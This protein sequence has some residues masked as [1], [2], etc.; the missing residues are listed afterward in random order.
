MNRL[1]LYVTA[2]LLLTSTAF[3][4]KTSDPST[5]SD[6]STASNLSGAVSAVDLTNNRLTTVDS[7]TN[8]WLFSVASTTAITLDGTATRL[9]YIKPGQNVTV[10]YS[11]S[12]TSEEM[13]ASRIAA[14]SVKSTETTTSSNSNLSGVVSAVDLINNRL[15]AVDSSNGSWLFSVLSTTAIKL[16]GNASRLGFIKSGQNVVVAYSTSSTSQEKVASRIAAT[17]VKSTDTTTPPPPQPPGN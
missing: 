16:D 7:S 13:V 4:Q 9:S 11:T 8:S 10:A 2:L 1:S 15:T 5:V 3:A 17:S 6:P 14:T 12:S